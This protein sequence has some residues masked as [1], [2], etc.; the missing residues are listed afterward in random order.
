MEIT[1]TVNTDKTLN[2]S[3]TNAATAELKAFITLVIA[4]LA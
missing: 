3:I 2:I 4:L 1:F